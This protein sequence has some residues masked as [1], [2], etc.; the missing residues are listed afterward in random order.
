MAKINA[1]G[2]VSDKDAPPEQSQDEP[3]VVIIRTGNADLDKKLTTAVS[4][5]IYKE[6]GK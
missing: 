2:V 3:I 6:L 4:R 5:Q 1:L